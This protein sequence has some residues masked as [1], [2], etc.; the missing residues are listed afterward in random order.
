MATKA[1]KSEGRYMTDAEIEALKRQSREEGIAEGKKRRRGSLPDKPGFHAVTLTAGDTE[2]NCLAKCVY[3][4]DEQWIGNAIMQQ[5]G[6]IAFNV[7]CG[8]GWTPGIRVVDGKPGELAA[9][10]ERLSGEIVAE[11][12]A[13]LRATAAKAA[14]SHKYVAKKKK[15]SGDDE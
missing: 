4:G 12:E 9:R 8:R 1:K 5:S 6:G 13:Y 2:G 10:V 3:N 15:K 11:C 7:Q 14:K